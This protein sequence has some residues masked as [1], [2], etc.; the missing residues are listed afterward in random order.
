MIIV[1]SVVVVVSIVAIVGIVRKNCCLIFVY[2]IFVV[3]FMAM[4][5]SIAIGCTMLPNL[6]FEGD[7]RTSKNSLI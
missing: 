4:F 1:S 5:V 2:Q 6:V 7:C 3:I